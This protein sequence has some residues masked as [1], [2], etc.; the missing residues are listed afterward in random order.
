[1]TYIQIAL[2]NLHCIALMQSASAANAQ[3]RFVESEGYKGHTSNVLRTMGYF[4]LV[5]LLHVH[6]LLEEYAAKKPN[7]S[8]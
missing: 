4:S 5:G 3:R 1:M 7:E 2:H 8:H 6:C